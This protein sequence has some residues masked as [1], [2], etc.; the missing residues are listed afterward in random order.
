MKI[1]LSFFAV[2]QTKV[3]NTGLHWLKAKKP[4]ILKLLGSEMIGK[5]TQTEIWN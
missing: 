2:H 4:G 5:V 3:Y 1:N